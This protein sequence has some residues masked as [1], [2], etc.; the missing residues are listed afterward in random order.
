MNDEFKPLNCND[1]DV[2]ASGNN[3]YKIG[4]FKKAVNESFTLLGHKFSEQLNSKGVHVKS[5]NFDMW[6]KQGVDCEILNLGSKTWK[7]GKVKITINVEFYAE[8][9]K[10]PE[11]TE[12]ES[13]L[14]DIRRMINEDRL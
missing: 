7:K 12:P 11:I 5:N 9:E 13:P 10:N 8:E 3:T 6:F 2:L 4:K 1:D 14:D